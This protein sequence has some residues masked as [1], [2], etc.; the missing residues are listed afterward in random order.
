VIDMPGAR[1]EPGYAHVLMAAA[2]YV[3]LRGDY[4]RADE[5]R[6]QAE[7]VGPAHPTTM[8]WP[9]VELASYN[10]TAMAA[11]ST[12]DYSTAVSAYSR[13]AELAAAAGYP[14]LAAVN[15]AVGVNAALLGGSEIPE[16]IAQAE[17]ALTLARQSR[18]HAAIVMSLN[19]PAWTLADRDATRAKRLLEESI[20]LCASP[21][22]S[23]PSGV[24]TACMAAARLSEWDLTLAMAA[25]S[26]HLER[27]ITAPMQ[28]APC[29]AVCARAFAENR[30]EPAGVLHGAANATF[31]R[32]ASEAG[33]LARSATTPV[34]PHGNF[35]LRALHEVGDIVANALGDQRANELRTVG[36]A[37]SMD[38]ALTY[39]LANIEPKLRT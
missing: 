30:P 36:N 8:H 18:M 22:E 37:M 35:I 21:V 28:V 38:E 5:L 3:Y 32:A 33:S 31:R 14:G 15:F 7:Q 1:E 9:P 20:K 19:S 23:S 11:L 27:W 26:M 25:R 2:W 13:G 39:A 12:G 29:L 34:G 4:D 16:A 6:R 10:Y 24:L 17:K